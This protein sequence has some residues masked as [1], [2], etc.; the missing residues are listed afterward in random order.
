MRQ[1]QRKGHYAYERPSGKKNKEEATEIALTVR[2]VPSKEGPMECATCVECATHSNEY[3]SEEHC[4]EE[5]EGVMEVQRRVYVKFYD[6]ND[7]DKE[8]L[9]DEEEEWDDERIPELE[10]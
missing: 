6:S 5:S 8:E 2:K 4:A 1:L 7:E 9:D 10:T 3:N